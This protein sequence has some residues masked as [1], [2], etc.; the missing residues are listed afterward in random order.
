M[1]MSFSNPCGHEMNMIQ[2]SI[3]VHFYHAEVSYFTM[4]CRINILNSY[5]ACTGFT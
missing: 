4:S 2:T 1:T 5:F 3:E